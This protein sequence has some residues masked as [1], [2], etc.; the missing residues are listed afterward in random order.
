[1]LSFYASTPAYAPV[2]E[3]HGWGEIQPRLQAMVRE[4]L[5]HEMPGLIDDEMLGALSVRG[6]PKEIAAELGRRYSDVADRAGFYLPYAHDDALATE[7]I[8]A[9]RE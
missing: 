2:L 4:G 8:E 5:W 7:I 1:L 9:V 3:L 6:V